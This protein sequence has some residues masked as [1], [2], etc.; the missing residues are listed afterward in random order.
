MTTHYHQLGYG[1]VAKAKSGEGGGRDKAKNL[2]EIRP[3][4]LKQTAYAQQ[5]LQ[6]TVLNRQRAVEFM[7]GIS[8]KPNAY[9]PSGGKTLISLQVTIS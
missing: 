8:L 9:R 1:R 2:Q 6:L 5:P 7:V 3:D 4:D